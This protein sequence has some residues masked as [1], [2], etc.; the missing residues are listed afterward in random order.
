MAQM[1]LHVHHTS[2]LHVAIIMDG[3][4]RWALRRGLPRSAGHGEGV[5]A[6]RRVVEAAP[7]LGVGTLTLHA[8]SGDN[9]QR[10]QGEVDTLMELLRDYFCTERKRHVDQGIRVSVIG[11]RDRLSPS[12]R[13]AVEATET[14]TAAGD[15]M[16]LRIAVDYSGR[17]LIVQ[18]AHRLSETREI[19]RQEFSRALAEV[20]HAGVETPEVDLIIR[21]GGEQRLSDFLLWESAYAELIFCPKMW[22]DFTG[23][24]LEMAVREFRA[25]ERRFGIVPAVAAS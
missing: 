17:D 24:D 7:A 15:M 10:P 2:R 8:F 25:R 19:S 18:A 23:D 21:S 6:V 3:N 4:G 9:W 1:T 12:L 13:A 11:R 14:A 22:P 20:S 16:H 5:R